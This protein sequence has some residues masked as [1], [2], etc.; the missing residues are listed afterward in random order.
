MCNNVTMNV[1]RTMS[2]IVCWSMFNIQYS[3]L[4]CSTWRCANCQVVHH[5]TLAGTIAL[6]SKAP[7][8]VTHANMLDTVQFRISSRAFPTLFMILALALLVNQHTFLRTFLNLEVKEWVCWALHMNPLPLLNWWKLIKDILKPFVKR[9][10]RKEIR[11]KE[12]FDAGMN[13]CIWTSVNE[14]C[15]S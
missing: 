6:P 1:W 13:V 2:C 3:T 4:L 7:P 14:K 8:I 9:V 5:D 15:T 10:R 11:S 12:R